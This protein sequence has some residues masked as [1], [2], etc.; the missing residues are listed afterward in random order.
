[1]LSSLSSRPKTSSSL[2]R[3]MLTAALLA[4]SPL[5]GPLAG[6]P[7]AAQ[8]NNLFGNLFKPPGAPAQSETNAAAEA[9]MRLDRMENA[10]RQLTGQVEELQYRNQQLEAQVKRLSEEGGGRPGAA[11]PAVPTAAPRVAPAP[12]SPGRRSDAFDP[13]GD[14]TA[15][16]VPQ[17][18]GSPASASAGLTHPNVGGT[19]VAA[20][21]PSGSARELYDAGQAQ[22]QRQDFTTAEQ[23]FRQIIQAN[24]G[25]RL[26]PDATFM[27]GESL[28]LRHNYGDAAAQFLEVSTKYPNS[29]R[30][31][32]ALLRLGQSLAG[33]GEKETACATFLE[34]D[35]KYPRAASAIRQA[36]EREQKRVG[37]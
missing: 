17:P 13:L 31:P 26:I 28:F 4:A 14:P 27:L 16:G 35:R 2:T 32:E 36:V 11:P 6:Q 33:L 12:A 5:V 10:L 15:P 22:I 23:T 7:A 18:L 1:M 8:D 25:D 29:T 19:Q 37:C 9:A 3:L 21:P 34:V 20:L 24:P 30:A